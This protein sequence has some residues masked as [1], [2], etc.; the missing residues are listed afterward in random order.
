M[1]TNKEI[2]RT[3]MEQSAIDANC[4]PEWQNALSEGRKELDVLGVG[5]YDS[6]GIF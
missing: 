2:L 4:Q 5:A 1:M 3:A 6:D